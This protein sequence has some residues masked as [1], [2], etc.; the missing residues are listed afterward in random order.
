MV[1]KRI[2]DEFPMDTN[3]KNN[4]IFSEV[5]FKGYDEDMGWLGVEVNA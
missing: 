3:P 5:L 1:Q 2:D 4:S